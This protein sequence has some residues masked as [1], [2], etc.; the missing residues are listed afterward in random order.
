[1][2][3]KKV[4][5]IGRDISCDIVIPDTTDVVSRVHATLRVDKGG[6]YILVDQSRNGTY[7]NGMRMTSGAEIPVSRKDVISFAHVCNLDWNVVPKAKR[8]LWLPLA[9]LAAV[10]VAVV[11]MV[12][13]RGG[14]EKSGGGPIAADSIA[15]DT[16]P[17]T[18][19]AEA[20]ARHDSVVRETI[21]YE[22]PVPVVAHPKKKRT[23]KAPADKPEPKEQPKEEP[24][25]A[26]KSE[27]VVQPLI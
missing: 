6:K 25:A 9:V 1:M 16:V 4:Y 15:T 14:P 23:K 20:P 26:D 21:F 24:K 18:W 12:M 8:T 17:A 3:N 10:V 27:E 5:S 2:S 19:E 11:M 13:F 22:R 7:V